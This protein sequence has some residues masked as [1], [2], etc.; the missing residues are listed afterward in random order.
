MLY[1]IRRFAPLKFSPDIFECTLHSET[2]FPTFRG[3]QWLGAFGGS[4][5]PFLRMTIGIALSLLY[6]P[7]AQAQ[8]APSLTPNTSFAAD[9]PMDRAGIFVQKSGWQELTNEMPAKTKAKRG[10]V[11]SL[12]YGTIPAKIVAEYE[13]PHAR[14]Q[15]EREPLICICHLI[16]LPGEPVLV[17]LHSKKNSRELDGGKM[18]VY[19]V[20]GGS[21][22][23][24]ANKSDLIP[25]DV[26]HP[27]PHVWLI[28]PQSPLIG[29]EY[30][31]ML[32]TQ[33]VNIYP[34]T[35]AATSGASAT[36]SAERE[37]SKK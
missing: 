26:A 31:L 20:V 29:G 10:I 11:A 30:A 21:K 25:V 15:L 35:V 8:A 6:L 18:I 33:N 37:K 14:M 34:F 4:M 22:T 7:F 2:T 36:A 27:D 16:S 28:R 17:R 13:D 24:D 9:Y 32:G 23:A 3:R 12:S 19:P 5:K 1:E